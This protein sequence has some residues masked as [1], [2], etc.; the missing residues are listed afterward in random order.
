M[1][2]VLVAPTAW[3][4]LLLLAAPLEDEDLK[5]QSALYSLRAME[6]MCAAIT[7]ETPG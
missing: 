1:D 5:V 2:V 3:R 7:F 6:I 4:P